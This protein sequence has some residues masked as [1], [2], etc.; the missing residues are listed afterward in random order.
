MV[1]L[2]QYEEE[3]RKHLLNLPC[4]SF[5]T[6]PPDATVQRVNFCLSTS[7]DCLT[8]TVFNTSGNLSSTTTGAD[9]CN[10]VTPDKYLPALFTLI[11]VIRV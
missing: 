8:T 5:A 9:I 6:T 3:E 11:P 4:P 1:R 2:E 7:V 10:Q